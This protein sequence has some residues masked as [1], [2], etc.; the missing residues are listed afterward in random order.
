MKLPGRIVMLLLAAFALIAAGCG[1]DDSTSAR[2]LTCGATS[3]GGRHRPGA[4]VSGADVAAGLAT[5][6][7]VAAEVAAKTAT[8][9]GAGKTAA[10]GLEPH[11]AP[12]EDRVKA[13]DPDAYIAIEDAMALLESGDATKAAA[14]APRSRPPSAPT[15]R[16]TRADRLTARPHLRRAPRGRH[17]RGVAP[18]PRHPRHPRRGALGA[19]PALAA[20]SGVEKARAELAQSRVMLAQALDLARAG[21]REQ[22]YA[23][24]RSAYLDHF[25][26]AE[27]PLRLR[28]AEPH[29]RPGVQVRDAAQR[30]Q[31]RRAGLEARGGRARHPGRPRRREA[32]DVEHRHRRPADRLRLLVQHPLPRGRRGG[33][34]DRHPARLARRRTGAGTT[35]GRSRGASSR[36]CSR[37]SSRGSSR[38]S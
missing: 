33:A 34:A 9:A 8:D 4:R 11:W 37:R 6:V 15:S 3:D 18:R 1:G 36:R 21:D 19:S 28:D 32:G 30:H 13:N 29:A 12:I 17:G 14:G 35:A 27:V 20:D 5:M 10:E 24:A 23:V 16:S 31:G 25:E 26:F 7:T 22:A 2:R 38:R